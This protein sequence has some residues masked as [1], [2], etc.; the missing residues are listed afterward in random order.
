M[1]R[2]SGSL[3]VQLTLKSTSRPLDAVYL[4]SLIQYGVSVGD[5][6]LLPLVK[7][8]EHEFLFDVDIELLGTLEGVYFVVTS[9]K[10]TSLVTVYID[11]RP[12]VNLEDYATIVLK[13]AF[14]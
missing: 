2:I 9:V 13:R 5:A 4:L 3:S 1:G 12:E 7:D 10:G 14:S 8:I 11:T 6:V